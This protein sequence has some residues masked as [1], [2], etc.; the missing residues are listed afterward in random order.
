MTTTNQPEQD[1][2]LRLCAVE[3][4]D[5]DAIADLFGEAFFEIHG[6]S[7]TIRDE[8]YRALGQHHF[9]QAAPMLKPEGFCYSLAQFDPPCHPSLHLASAYVS[10]FKNGRQIIYEK[11]AKTAATAL[12]AASL[13]AHRAKGA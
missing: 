6:A 13:A 7:S 11:D 3:R 9:D 1:L 4:D 10:D 8:F 2:I 12:A 5:R